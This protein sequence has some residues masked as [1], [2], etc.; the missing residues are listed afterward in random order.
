M[1]GGWEEKEKA[2]IS[3]QVR[4]FLYRILLF[5]PFEKENLKPDINN[6]GNPTRARK[7]ALQ[8]ENIKVLQN[9]KILA[10]ENSETD[11]LRLHGEVPG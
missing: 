10:S 5:S 11:L 4:I 6:W 7:S 2:D 3:L 8:L 1:D 9:R